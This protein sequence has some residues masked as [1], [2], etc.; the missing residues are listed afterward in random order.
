MVSNEV[1]VN[2]INQP[3]G[4]FPW[5]DLG[6][7]AYRNW[8]NAHNGYGVADA[9]AAYDILAERY[10]P[11]VVADADRVLPTLWSALKRPALDD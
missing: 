9:A 11:A 5:I 1:R 4:G 10:T 6:E 3:Y 2:V 8:A 7:R